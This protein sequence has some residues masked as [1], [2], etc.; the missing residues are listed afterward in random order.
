MVNEAFITLMAATQKMIGFSSHITPPEEVGIGFYRLLV[1]RYP[2]MD[3]KMWGGPYGGA[4]TYIV[5]T[6]PISLLRR[7]CDAI[8]RATL[9]F[10]RSREYVTIKFR[11]SCFTVLF[12]ECDA[13]GDRVNTRERSRRKTR[14]HTP[15]STMQHLISFE[16]EDPRCIDKLYDKIDTWLAP[17]DDDEDGQI[18]P[19]RGL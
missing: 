1:D 4:S 16:Y 15:P 5:I 12:E 8:G 11:S 6:K 18:T 10:G 2:D 14:H 13:R 9:G 19:V 7:I 17:C 3:V